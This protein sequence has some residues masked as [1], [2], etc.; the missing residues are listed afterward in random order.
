MIFYT[1]DNCSKYMLIF[2]KFY[3]ITSLL[4]YKQTVSN[5]VFKILSMLMINWFLY[6]TVIFSKKLLLYFIILKKKV[7][8]YEVVN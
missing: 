4:I 7:E 2:L 3:P 1:F 8:G 5:R 6:F